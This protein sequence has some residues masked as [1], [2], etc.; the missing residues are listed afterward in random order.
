MQFTKNFALYVLT[1]DKYIQEIDNYVSQILL[2]RECSET[3]KGY[4]KSHV[5]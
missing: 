2:L 5:A 1:L 4:I 3:F